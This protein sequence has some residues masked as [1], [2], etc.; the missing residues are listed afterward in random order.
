M[1]GKWNNRNKW[2][3]STREQNETKVASNG[4][5][6][7]NV[8]S[9][10]ILKSGRATTYFRSLHSLNVIFNEIVRYFELQYFLTVFEKLFEIVFD[11]MFNYIIRDRVYYR[12]FKLFLDFFPPLCI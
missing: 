2:V 1:K 10:Y 12:S 7:I 3:K 11:F 4:L 8:I 9:T 5:P 6:N